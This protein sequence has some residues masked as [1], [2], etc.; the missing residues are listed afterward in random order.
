MLHRS[1]FRFAD[2]SCRFR[3]E[4]HDEHHDV[5]CRQKFEQ[6]GDSFYT[7]AGSASEAND[8]YAEGRKAFFDRPADRPVADDHHALAVQLFLQNR[9]QGFRRIGIHRAVVKVGFTAALPVA[10]ALRLEVEGKMLEGCENGGDGPLC[11]RDVVQLLCIAEDE[12]GGQ[13]L[14][15]PVNPCVQRLH[16]LQA[17][18]MR[19]GL[20]AI[21]R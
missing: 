16:N 11:R 8:F 4:G 14:Q 20:R 9:R 17:L 5:G 13:Y 7:V 15:Q 19:Q 1:E 10:G 18:K 12:I 6:A 2:H 21:P 3:R